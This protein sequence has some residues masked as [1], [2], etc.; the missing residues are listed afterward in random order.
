[1]S[2]F[3]I[4]CCAGQDTYGPTWQGHEPGQT[5]LHPDHPDFLIEVAM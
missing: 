4:W 5:E 2:R 1:M 3:I